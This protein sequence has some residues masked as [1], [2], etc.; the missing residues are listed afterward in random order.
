MNFFMKEMNSTKGVSSEENVNLLRNVR[1]LEHTLV[2]IQVHREE[3][4]DKK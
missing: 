2:M 3:R 4:T 1:T